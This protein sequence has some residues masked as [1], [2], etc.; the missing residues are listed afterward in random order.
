MPESDT[1]C[2]VF[3]A[4]DVTAIPPVTAPAA[5]GE[6][7]TLKVVLCPADNVNGRLI[8]LKLNPVPLGV[9]WEI[10]TPEPPVFVNVC[11]RVTL[12]LIATLPKF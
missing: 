10:V 9:I 11:N 12:L 5:A 8:P 1:L 6:N 2:V 7:V 4:V 3:D